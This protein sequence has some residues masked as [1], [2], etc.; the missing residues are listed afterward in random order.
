MAIRNK[1]ILHSIDLANGEGLEIGPLSAPIVQKNQ[2]NIYYLDLM[3]KS[4]LKEKYKSDPINPDEIVDIDYIL[5]GKS[6]AETVSGKKFDYV[7][8]SHVI[9]HVPNMAKWLQEVAEILKPGGVLSLVIPDKRFTFDINREETLPSE[10]LGTYIDELKK[11]PSSIV[12]D[13]FSKYIDGVDTKK[14]WDDPS[15]YKKAKSRWSAQEAYE[16]CIF[17]KDPKNYIDCHCTV[18]TP[19]S[20]IR[21][22]RELVQLDLFDYKVS[23]FVTTQQYELEFYVSLSRVIGEDNNKEPQLATLP[24][25]RVKGIKNDQ[26]KEIVQLKQEIKAI[27]NSVS[28]RVTSPIRKAKTIERNIKRLI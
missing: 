15:L 28:W 4:D 18:L 24:K 5:K 27:T 16:K 10:V 11:P 19:S 12:Y 21:I 2:G 1:R 17:N 7:I 9:E 25:V 20:F 26:F 23:H 22:L 13:F 14:A 6:L 3:S 8:A